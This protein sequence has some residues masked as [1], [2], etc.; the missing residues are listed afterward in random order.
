MSAT[1]TL[2]DPAVRIALRKDPSRTEVIREGWVW[3]AVAEGGARTIDEVA[4]YVI[5]DL[6]LEAERDIDG[7]EAVAAE[8]NAIASDD[9]FPDLDWAEFREFA[10]VLLCL[11]AAYDEVHSP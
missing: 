8:L 10:A 11:A 9:Q 5:G 6:T 2:C 3:C 1:A 4:E 7:L